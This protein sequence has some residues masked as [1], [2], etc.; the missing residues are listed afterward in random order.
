MA[1]AVTEAELSPVDVASSLL[2]GRA[3][4]E[5]RA[6]VIGADAAALVAGLQAVAAGSPAENVVTGSAVD[7]RLVVVL[8]G[9]GSQRAG[10]GRE[11]YAAF[12]VFA[13]A[14]DAVC[15]Q[16]DRWLERP[17]REVVFD[18]DADLEPT[19][20]AQPGLFAI[21]VALFRLIESWGITPDVLVGHSIGEVAAA[22]VAG[23]LDLPRRGPVGRG[24][25]HADA[26]VAGP[27]GRCWRSAPTRPPCW[28]RSRGRS[29]VAVAAVNAPNAVVV[30]GDAMVI[31]E[32]ERELGERFRIRRLRV[33][34]AFH[35]PLM[36][37][38][39][40]EFR[41]VAEQLTYHASTIPIVS[42]VTGVEDP[43]LA[44][45]GY[46]VNQVRATVRFADALN[47]AAARVAGAGA[48]AAVLELGPDAVLAPM[49]I[50]TVDGV[51][52][53]AA[54]RRGRD[55]ATTLLSAVAGVYT[56]G[57]GVDW[58]S[59]LPRGRR[60]DLPTYAFQHERFWVTTRAADA[61]LGAAGLAG[62]GHPLL[63]ALVELPDAGVV[64]TGRLSVAAQPWLADHVVGGVIVVPGT[65]VLEMVIQAGDRVGCGEV[66]RLTL[67]VP[68][69]V[70]PE[71][72]VAVQLMV[73]AAG[74]AGG[75][76]LTLR[77]RSEDTGLTGPW[78]RHAS[79]RLVRAAAA[80]VVSEA[81]V[82]WPPVGAQVVPVEGL[83]SRLAG[84]GLEYGPLFQGLRA[85]WRGEG[86]VFAEVELPPDGRD[87]VARFGLHPALLDAGLHA[88]AFGDVVS[89]EGAALPFE[90]ADVSL[91][92]TGGGSVAGPARGHRPGHRAGAGV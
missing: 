64:L 85:V 69:V 25:G 79:G 20:W 73:G 30:S 6:A 23:V 42:T 92:A 28:R 59:V 4:L 27:V 1:A 29:G 14:F 38:M 11:L 34:H 41:V 39:L 22:H 60:V 82:V 37:P 21:E 61:D 17:L 3:V 7:A 54:G 84:A 66:E 13:A 36:D 83:Y 77:S 12:P 10:M 89:T 52:V 76:E 40:D 53:H 24:A 90:W 50:A 46:W 19:G 8:S 33:S 55:E 18:P 88:I 81:L 35:S 86:E 2:T 16:L 72:G 87:D 43:D 47:A 65:A 56:A 71:G 31:E 80:G 70:P 75:R 44:T 74:E 63:S 58:T 68:L 26:G 62:T 45:A 32:L 78:V 48:R 49:V 67:E 9:Q 51:S 5:Q 15:E 57:V 91:R